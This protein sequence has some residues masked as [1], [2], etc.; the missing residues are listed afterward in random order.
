MALDLVRFFCF[1]CL[2]PPGRGLRGREDVP[3][4]TSKRA[5]EKLEDGETGIS[6]DG[7]LPI[8]EFQRRA[9]Q[10][11]WTGLSASQSQG[12]VARYVGAAGSGVLNC[13]SWSRHLTK[14][15]G[16]Y[17]RFSTFIDRGTFQEKYKKMVSGGVHNAFETYATS[18]AGSFG[19]WPQH[20]RF[21][22]LKT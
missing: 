17:E 12:T 4:K 8:H 22:K 7:L 6:M 5:T 11:R 2:R 15:H 20:P 9:S 10:E 13:G 1:P 19:T 14:D 21:A 18:S 3:N 16:R